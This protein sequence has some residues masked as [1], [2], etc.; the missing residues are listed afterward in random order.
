MDIVYP[1]DFDD[2]RVRAGNASAAGKPEKIIR[3]KFAVPPVKVAC[4]E[5]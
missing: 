3:K 1:S 5:W 2:D 4:L